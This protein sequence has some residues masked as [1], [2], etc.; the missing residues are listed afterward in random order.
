MV[1]K[2]HPTIKQQ[3]PMFKNF[4]KN[5]KRASNQYLRQKYQ[6]TEEVDGLV[7]GEYMFYKGC[8]QGNYAHQRNR[9]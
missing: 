9:W 5:D 1:W 2:Q 3:L 6:L 4:E 8:N 7:F